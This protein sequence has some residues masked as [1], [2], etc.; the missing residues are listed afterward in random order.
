MHLALLFLNDS[1]IPSLTVYLR[2]LKQRLV[3]VCHSMVFSCE[4]DEKAFSEACLEVVVC[5]LRP[6]REYRVFVSVVTCRVYTGPIGAALL[7]RQS[8]LI[9][10]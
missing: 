4:N 2:V 5:G 7:N 8:L 6:F 3:F 10:P 1:C 9:S